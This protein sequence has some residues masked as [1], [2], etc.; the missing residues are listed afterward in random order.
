MTVVMSSHSKFK[1]HDWIS[2]SSP[3]YA[4]ISIVKSILA[5]KLIEMEPCPSKDAEKGSSSPMTPNSIRGRK[6]MDGWKS[7][8]FSDLK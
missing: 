5:N 1:Q 8:R 7:H 6:W 4:N 3:K 2:H